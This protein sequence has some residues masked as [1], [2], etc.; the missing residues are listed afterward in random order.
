MIQKNLLVGMLLLGMG[1]GLSTALA[2]DDESLPPFTYGSMENYQKVAAIADS[3]LKMADGELA[4]HE[5]EGLFKDR[6]DDQKLIRAMIAEAQALLQQGQQAEK[7]GDAFKAQIYYHSAEATAYYAAYM[8]HL[9][10]SRLEQEKGN[11]KH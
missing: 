11:H 3:Y 6:P 7:A 4:E 1:T 9:L 10:E 8:P 5:L 2:D